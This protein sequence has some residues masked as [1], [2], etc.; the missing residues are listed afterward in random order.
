MLLSCFRKSLLLIFVAAVLVSGQERP[1]LQV[2]RHDYSAG[3][4]LLIPFDGRA[5][6]THKLRMLARVAD[7]ELVLPPLGLLG[8]SSNPADARAIFKWVLEY[9]NPD[10]DAAI[11]SIDMLARGAGAGQ[12]IDLVMNS[13]RAKRP[14]LP[15][16]G[17]V[18]SDSKLISKSLELVASGRLDYLI[19]GAGSS[20]GSRDE[21][22][23]LVKEKKLAGRVSVTLSPDASSSLGAQFLIARALNRRFGL[24]PRFWV[25]VSSAEAVAGSL[26]YLG[27]QLASIDARVLPGTPEAS[28]RADLNIFL[29]T[30]GTGSQGSSALADAAAASVARGS[31]VAIADISGN[32]ES[33]DALFD[34]LRRRKLM[35]AL[36]SY[37]SSETPQLSSGEAI[38]HASVRLITMKFLRGD[39]DQ[40]HRAERAQIEYQFQRLLQQFVYGRDVRPKLESFV[41]SELKSDPSNLGAGR[42]RAEAFAR[43][44]IETVAEKLFAEQY[45]RNSHSILISTG[46][47]I[48]F[49]VGAL[50]RLQLRLGWGAASEL[51]IRPGIYMTVV[52]L[53]PPE[54]PGANASWELRFSGEREPRLVRRFGQIGWARFKANAENVYIEMNL[55]RRE[56]PAE[57]YSIIARKRGSIDRRIEVNAST[58]RGGF[59][60]LSK[61]E[62]LGAEG[63]LG[64]DLLLTESP[65]LAR[66]GIIE[67][68][69][70]M[71][72][73]HDRKDTIQF[74]GRVRMNRYYYAPETSAGSH[75]KWHEQLSPDESMRLQDILRTASDNF[76]DVSYGIRIGRPLT[77]SNQHDQ[78][79]LTGKLG[80]LLS[81]G[82]RGILLILPDGTD[83]LE[84]DAD[85]KQF[86]SL[87]EAQ[88]Q[89]ILRTHAYLKQNGSDIELAVMPSAKSEEDAT[90]YADYVKQLVS[91][92]PQEVLIAS[93]DASIQAVAP[94][95]T[96]DVER[97]P[98]NEQQPWRLFLGASRNAPKS[99]DQSA[100]ILAIPM[101]RAYPSMLPLAT[102]GDLAWN[103]RSYRAE[104]AIVNAMKL[105]YDDRT[106]SNMGRWL[107]VYGSYSEQ[108][109]LFE[110][111]FQRSKKEVDVV[112]ID[113]QLKELEEAIEG[114]GQTRENGLLRGELVPFVVRTRNALVVAT[115]DSE[116][117]K[118]PDG[119]LRRKNQ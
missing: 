105:L 35:D 83:A 59:Y 74:L 52:N 33:R 77:Y 10:T 58:A 15:I 106:A 51:D 45:Q 99:L 104:T 87:A 40:L 27:P 71:W 28:S 62:Q 16:Y 82:V 73:P 20:S 6:S 5:E 90:S 118:L 38:V 100:G 86:K 81:Q 80:S 41:Q 54:I 91:L 48:V 21:I 113:R 26:N 98:S 39:I 110:P 95:R 7:H 50:Q 19:I 25:G 70:S 111:L 17:F 85:R 14:D 32:A 64:E 30:A 116:F 24:K 36:V 1:R 61:L 42:D 101:N 102:I 84:N 2:A 56:I 67:G 18:S 72:S 4:F 65:S 76:V 8:E 96:I 53:L 23:A 107:G 117:E 12:T 29:Q 63:R 55:N 78:N 108:S 94:A 34:Q 44:E 69:D 97:F 88:A 22:D 3:K 57:G 47:R 79:L 119:R 115:S 13:I 11:L 9:G 93:S 43:K 112:E 103:G 60:A 31:R 114:I 66:R 109:H 75:S 37:A 46:E 49:E 92:L 89:L 68:F